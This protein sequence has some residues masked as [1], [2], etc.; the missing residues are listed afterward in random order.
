MLQLATGGIKHGLC[1]STGERVLETCAWSNP[2]FIPCT[3]SFADVALH[4]SLKEIV[5]VNRTDYMLSPV[6]SSVSLNLGVLR[7]TPTILSQ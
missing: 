2:D 1:D 6:S 4:P 7:R 3:F 5:A